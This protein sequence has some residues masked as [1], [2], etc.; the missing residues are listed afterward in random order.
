ME[1][2]DLEQVV[3]EYT[4]GIGAGGGRRLNNKVG[5]GSEGVDGGEGGG[6]A[7]GGGEGGE[8]KQ[9][10]KQPILSQ[11]VYDKDLHHELPRGR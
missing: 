9:E 7:E 8:L 4:E 2:R 10:H 11:L 3:G 6:V 1:G 5:A